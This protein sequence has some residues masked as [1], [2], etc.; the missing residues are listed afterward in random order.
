V[1]G[2]PQSPVDGLSQAGYRGARMT[3][4][5]SASTWPTSTR[6]ARS[7]ARRS[8]APRL[9][10]N[11]RT[12]KLT[13]GGHELYLI[14]RPEGSTPFLAA[15]EGRSFA[16][17]WTP[18][19]L[20]FSVEDVGRVHIGDHQARR[21]RRGP[22]VGRLGQPDALRRSLWQRLLPGHDVGTTRGGALRLRRDGGCPAC[23]QRPC[24]IGTSTISATATRLAIAMRETREP[25]V[26]PED[27]FDGRSAK[28]RNRRETNLCRRG[29]AAPFASTRPRRVRR[30][31]ATRRLRRLQSVG[32]RVS[33]RGQFS[34]VR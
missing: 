29:A 6:P 8:S 31:C 7:T 34:S 10:A 33:R 15:T 32:H 24:R 25:K 3:T 13:A 27:H 14:L 11:S 19:H 9:G 12:V 2:Q 18:V 17:H 20:D 1:V 4:V 23:S 21:N 22:G 5:R 26:R 30:R 16:R 28:S